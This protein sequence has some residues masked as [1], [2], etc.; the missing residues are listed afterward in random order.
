MAPEDRYDLTIEEEPERADVQR[1][2]QGLDAH[3]WPITGPNPGRDLAVFLRDQ[4]G[5]IVA[6]LE[7]GT[8]SGWL[9]VRYLWVTD[10]LRGQGW[11][12]RIMDVAEQEAAARGCRHIRLD[13]MSYQAR[14]FYEK[15]GFQVFAELDDYPGPHS[16]YLLRKDL[17]NSTWRSVTTLGDNR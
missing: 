9:S 3:G 14:G 2:L 5:A 13:T 1:L 6:G 10:E 7:G 4:E 12:R 17:P 11:G 15:L 8:W 16:M